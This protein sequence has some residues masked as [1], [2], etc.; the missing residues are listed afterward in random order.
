METFDIIL[1]A[2]LSIVIF[3]LGYSAVGVFTGKK[4]IDE[5]DN[6][7]EVTDNRVTDID[8]EVSYRIDQEVNNLNTYIRGIEKDIINDIENLEKD[9][10]AQLDSR[11]DKLENKFKNQISSG[12]EVKEALLEIQVLKNKLDEFIGT[13]QNQ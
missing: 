13:Y 1:G 9:L 5:L 8:R 4:R 3:L 2:L 6:F 10:Y 11:L 12:V 7:I